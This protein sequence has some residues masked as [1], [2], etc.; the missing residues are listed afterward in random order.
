MR[1][2]V[3]DSK[4]ILISY[5]LSDLC[6]QRIPVGLNADRLTFFASYH[7]I[8]LTYSAALAS[9]SFKETFEMSRTH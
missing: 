2:Q 1:R 4:I 7:R 6:I 3:L 5:S 8:N 9:S